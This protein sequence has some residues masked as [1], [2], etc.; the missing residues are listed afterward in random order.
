MCHSHIYICCCWTVYLLSC[1][2]PNWWQTAC[3]GHLS[4]IV[5]DTFKMIPSWSWLFSRHPKHRKILEASVYICLSWEERCFSVCHVLQD[6]AGL[7]NLLQHL[8]DLDD[9]FQVV[10]TEGL[11][12]ITVKQL[13][14]L[15]CL[16]VFSILVKLHPL[17]LASCWY[18][19]GRKTC[20]TKWIF[21][22]C[23]EASLCSTYDSG[24]MFY[25]LFYWRV[26]VSRPTFLIIQ[27]I[28]AWSCE[29]LLL[30]W[31]AS[32]RNIRGLAC[33]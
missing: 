20:H 10:I 14:F 17:I 18:S 25:T 3:S 27:M 7:Q 8:D 5:V 9:I 15:D 6:L 32:F 2:S 22:N 1:S 24:L 28:L 4:R 12:S 21:E 30:L 33:V 13:C 26:V 23:A 31:C 19:S 29:D 16:C 11:T